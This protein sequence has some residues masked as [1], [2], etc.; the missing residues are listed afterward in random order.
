MLTP[1][2]RGWAP[3]VSRVK[4]RRA[5]R[6]RHVLL[7]S[8]MEN[9]Y[10]LI[11]IATS[12]TLTLS[13]CSG[14]F[15]AAKN[16]VK[17]ATNGTLGVPPT[18]STNNTETNGNNTST[19]SVVTN[20]NIFYQGQ[21]TGNKISTSAGQLDY[22]TTRF[23]NGSETLHFEMKIPYG[24][25]YRE[26]SKIV[27]L[28]QPQACQWI[29]GIYSNDPSQYNTWE[30]PC[31]QILDGQW[32]KVI[33]VNVPPMYMEPGGFHVSVYGTNFPVKLSRST[34]SGTFQQ[35]DLDT[36]TDRAMVSSPNFG[37]DVFL[38]FR[39]SGDNARV[40]LCLN[41]PGGQVT[42]D[43]RSVWAHAEKW[44]A[45]VYFGYDSSF[46]I[47]PG[48]ANWDYGR[49]CVAAD[50]SWA[51]RGWF[52]PSVNFSVLQAPYLKNVN[53][54][55]LHIQIEDWFLRLVDNVLNTFNASFR[56]SIA[57]YLQNLGN[58]VADQDVESG[59]WYT[60]TGTDKLL[61]QA[62]DRINARLHDVIS[63][64]SL[65]ASSDDLK[66]ILRDQCR[67]KQLGLSA[68]WTARLQAFCNTAIDQFDITIEPF[69]V[70]PDS[71][72]AG[73]YDYYANIHDAD[74]KWWA[75]QC[76]FTARFNIHLTPTATTYIDLVVKLLED[77]IGGLQIPPNWQEYINNSGLGEYGMALLMEKLQQLGYTQVVPANWTQEIPELI[78]QIKSQL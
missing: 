9:K 13:A 67:L 49:T 32:K 58:S 20:P 24:R 17:S 15:E 43:A 6:V 59:H 44:V 14:G 68:E 1:A 70:D 62:A 42:S 53:Y 66:N 63:R 39:P 34:L 4:I 29:S 8:S 50:V 75:N 5:Q 22:Y 10:Y 71:Q 41:V 3:S 25:V 74:T 45:G 78:Q 31:G 38:L 19:G 76:H 60:M 21:S 7:S 72:A 18:P 57:N 40:E 28:M 77:H 69:A 37:D 23:L 61:P 48:A 64:L 2:E 52:T 54:Q 73:C 27:R 30:I 33:D 56:L 16:S 11:G 46:N 47:S 35:K 12:F 36:K 26:A 55:G 65:P 51:T